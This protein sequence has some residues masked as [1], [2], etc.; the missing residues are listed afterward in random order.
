MRSLHSES[1]VDEQH[2]PCDERCLVGAEEAYRPGQVCWLAKPSKWRVAEQRGGCLLWQ[3]V[4]E[5]R[6]HVTRCDGVCTHAAAAELARER[7][8]EPDD[9]GFRRR[10][11]RL[12]PVA[13]HADD[14]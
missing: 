14:G 5:L 7:L 4:G 8:R 13:V 1:A 12:P 2:V 9:P 3:N 11:V 10:I 6:A